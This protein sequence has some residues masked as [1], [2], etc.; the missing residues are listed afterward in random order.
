[1]RYRFHYLVK[2]YDTKENISHILCFRLPVSF[3]DL[4]SVIL[5]MPIV[6][7]EH[8]T[9][10]SYTELFFQSTIECLTQKSFV[11]PTEMQ[12]FLFLTLKIVTFCSVPGLCY[13]AFRHSG[14]HFN[15]CIS[16]Y[17]SKCL[18]WDEES[19]GALPYDCS[20]VPYEHG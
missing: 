2:R 19:L 17:K 7:C 15:L 8:K 18:L 20:T 1:M 13:C 11:P 6:I 9:V 5:K 16:C 3:T 12:T 10:H 4:T 14:A